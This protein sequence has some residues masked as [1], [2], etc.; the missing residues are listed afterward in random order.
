M[1]VMARVVDTIWQNEVLFLLILARIGA[2][3][4][5]IPLLGSGGTPPFVK[6]LVV[7]AMTFVMFPIVKDMSPVPP[8]F[9]RIEIWWFVFALISELLV[10]WV[11]GFVVR[12]L[13]AAVEIGSEV[14]GMQ[15]GFGMANAFDPVSQQQVSLIRQFHSVFA[16][17]LFLA[18][19][20][21]HVVLQAMAKSFEWIPT[22]SFMIKG[23]VIEQILRMGSHMFMLG[24]K[25]AAPVT[26]ALVLTQVAM[27]VLSR[28]VP[29]IQIFLIGFPLTIGLGLIVF[30]ASLNLYM[31]LLQNEMTGQLER[32]LGELLM[33]MRAS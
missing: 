7:V 31:H 24:M 14:A 8:S 5:A 12:A 2:F 28:A 17:L 25:V 1:N 10:G 29:Q 26:V 33:A 13:F 23:P 21:H 4:T 6:A 32:T 20:C 18:I 11:I 9:S 27:G 30:G 19:N 22:S 3:L 15:M 16:S